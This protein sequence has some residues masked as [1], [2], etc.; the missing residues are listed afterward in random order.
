MKRFFAFAGVGAC[1]MLL[2]GCAGSTR[3]RYYLLDSLPAETAVRGTSEESCGSVGVGPVKMA[4]YLQRLEIITRPAPNELVFSSFD[5]WAE[6]LIDS[7]PRTLAENVSRLTCAKDLS[8]YPWKP[9]RLP[10]YRVE[11]QVLSMD[12][13]LGGTVDLEVWWSIF[14]G[15]DKTTGR[16]DRKSRYSVPVSRH[17]YEAL[18]Q[19]HSQALAALSRDV[20]DALRDV[21]KSHPPA[22]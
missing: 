5:L 4:E 11:A 2:V 9:S 21:N 19:A 3:S 17:S 20:A 16:I 10:D 8:L 18:V 1:L 15:A 6:P 12:G 13:N 22:K 14:Y 7:F